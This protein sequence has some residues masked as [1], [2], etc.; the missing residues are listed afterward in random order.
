MTTD[1]IT[2]PWGSW[3]YAVCHCFVSSVLVGRR[4]ATADTAVAHGLQRC[5]V[6][7]RVVGAVARAE[8]DGHRGA[9]R[10]RGDSVQSFAL[11]HAG[12]DRSCPLYPARTAGATDGVERTLTSATNGRGVLALV[13][14]SWLA[15]GFVPRVQFF[16][17]CHSVTPAKRSRGHG[18]K[19]RNVE[20]QKHGDSIPEPDSRFVTGFDLAFR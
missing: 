4:E 1:G 14:E 9:H 10:P 3:L 15:D 16:C 11:Q 13:C 18:G 19:R 5:C 2:I 8:S 7:Q 12:G 20:T 17:E 6:Q